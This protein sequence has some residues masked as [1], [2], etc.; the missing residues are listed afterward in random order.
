MHEKEQVPSTASISGLHPS[1]LVGGGGVCLE[2]M[3]SLFG[4]I[5]RAVAA[6]LTFGRVSKFRALYSMSLVW[7]R[8]ALGSIL[9]VSPL[10]AAL[11]LRVQT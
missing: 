11:G 8:R 2:A 3:R 7:G 1:S 10:H 4:A 5:V 6:L 9:A